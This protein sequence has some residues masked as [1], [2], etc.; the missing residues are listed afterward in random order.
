M[1]AAS[2]VLSWSRGRR[3]ASTSGATPSLMLNAVLLQATLKFGLI[4]WISRSLERLPSERWAA[5]GFTR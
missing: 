4:F 5:T 3:V 1:L 2:A